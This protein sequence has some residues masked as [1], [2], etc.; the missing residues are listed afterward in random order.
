[1]KLK[2][3]VKY[4]V[5]KIVKRDKMLTYFLFLTNTLIKNSNTKKYVQK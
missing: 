4:L 1:M 3:S 2:K 5:K